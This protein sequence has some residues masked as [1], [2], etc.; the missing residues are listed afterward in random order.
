MHVYLRMNY[1]KVK[2]QFGTK[3]PWNY[4]ILVKVL[5]MF[6]DRCLKTS[7]EMKAKQSYF[8]NTI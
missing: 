3:I 5:V 8:F 4:Y 7:K 2:F 1:V 6:E